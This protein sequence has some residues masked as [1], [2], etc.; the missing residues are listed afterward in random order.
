MG[1]PGGGPGSRR[2]PAWMPA[3]TLGRR[4]PGGAACF[5]AR[6]LAGQDGELTWERLLPAVCAPGSDAAGNGSRRPGSPA[7]ALRAGW[8]PGWAAASRLTPACSPWVRAWRAS[9]GSG[10]PAAAVWQRRA[11]DVSPDGL[12]TA[13]SPRCGRCPGRLG[14][15][16]A[17]CLPGRRRLMSGVCALSQPVSQRPAATALALQCA[18]VVSDLAWP[19]AVRAASGRQ[20]AR[21]APALGPPPAGWQ[22]TPA[23]ARRE[24]PS[25][26]GVVVRLVG[27]A[28][29][30][31]ALHAHAELRSHGLDDRACARGECGGLLL[32]RVSGLSPGVRAAD[33]VQRWG[34]LSHLALPGR[35]R[36]HHG[37]QH[38]WMPAACL[39]RRPP[40]GSCLPRG[41]LPGSCRVCGLQGWLTGWS[42]ET[43]SQRCAAQ[44]VSARARPAALLWAAPGSARPAC[45]FWR[46]GPAKGNTVFHPT[47]RQLPCPPRGAVCPI[48]R[49][50]SVVRVCLGTLPQPCCSG[51]AQPRRRH[52]ARAAR[53]HHQPGLHLLPAS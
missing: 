35:A 6:R 24:L 43:S 19:L 47:G 13:R 4:P 40:G 36:F 28:A 1:A 49:C 22:Q 52:A 48:S 53:G 18:L 25:A 30:C 29:L 14:P 2:A 8:A 16:G 9:Q 3:C 51:D 5:L 44:V 39:R 15:A 23:A 32:H 31:C 37:R 38:T 11:V 10:W 12:G 33:A 41:A 46:G 42:M 7:P 34:S 26:P 45:A 20:G 21:V 27:C 17:P 50:R